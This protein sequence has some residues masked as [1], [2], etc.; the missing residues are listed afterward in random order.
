MEAATAAVAA[1]WRRSPPR[2]RPVAAS[3]AAN[4]KAPVRAPMSV[5]VVTQ[6]S[7]LRC[8]RVAGLTPRHCSRVLERGAGLS[9]CARNTICEAISRDTPSS[10][11][12]GHAVR[13]NRTRSAAGTFS[14]HRRRSRRICQQKSSCL[15]QP[16]SSAWITLTLRENFDKAPPCTRPLPVNNP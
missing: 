8:R 10:Q 6:I 12:A 9:P 16:L 7:S 13:R 5:I 3:A 2:R 14:G 15:G 4:K 1:S 11:H